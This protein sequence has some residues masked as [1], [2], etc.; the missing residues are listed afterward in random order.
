[1]RLFHR[2]RLER[3][4]LATP[5][6]KCLGVEELPVLVAADHQTVK[7]TSAPEPSDV[8]WENLAKDKTFTYRA[9]LRTFVVTTSMIGIGVAIQVG[10]KVGQQEGTPD[11]LAKQGVELTELQASVY[12]LGLSALASGVVVIINLLLKWTIKWLVGLEGHD[13]KTD[14]ERSVFTKL[15][16]AYILNTVILPM[17]LGVLPVGVGVSQAWYEAGGVVQQAAILM[18]TNFVFVEGLK[19]LQIYPLTMRYLVAPCVVSQRRKND[20]WAPPR[21]LCAASPAPHR[22]APATVWHSC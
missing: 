18:I 21:M 8:F 1:M 19:V 7:L 6:A 17:V 20:L 3:I 10:I 16:M 15:S 4:A 5:F 2:T 9:S 22:R 14:F 11:K 13:T 12:S